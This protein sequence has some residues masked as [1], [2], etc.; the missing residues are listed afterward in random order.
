MWKSRGYGWYLRLDADGYGLY[1]VTDSACVEFERGSSAEFEG[2]FETLPSADDSQLRL[3]IRNDI[4]EYDFDRVP[5]LPPHT[6]ALDDPENHDIKDNFRFFCEAFE[7]DY[8]F[9]KLRNVDWRQACAESAKRLSR[10]TSSDE[11]FSVL[12]EL[13]LPLEDNHIV[14]TDG[15]QRVN[16]EKIADIKALIQ[17]S[18]GLRSASIGNP[19]S[20]NTLCPYLN[21]EF[22]GGQATIAGNN[23]FLWGMVE[24]GVGYLG[25]LRFF[26]LAANNVARMATD[27][28]PRRP[29]HAEFM[30]HDLEAVRQI[31]RSAMTDLSQ[32]N[33]IIVDVRLNGGGF[34]KVGMMVADHF[35]DRKRLAFSKQARVGTSLS[36]RQ[37]FHIE[38]A[39][40][41]GF[42][43]P[44]YVLTSE[45]T[46]SAGDVFALCMRALPHATL[47][48]RPSAGILSDNLTKHLPNGWQT[49]ISNEIYRAPD[50]QVFEG[51]GVPV[52]IE[53]PIF[54]K[55]DFAAGYKVAFDLARD[56]STGRK[57][58]MTAF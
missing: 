42:T 53:T 43:K 57:A 14:L 27:L 15:E 45:R 32:A 33:A 47:I 34:D 30:A 50:D 25:A 39:V 4:T 17:S 1:D 48:G 41:H 19:D 35:T 11:L 10:E 46:A 18:L 5:T 44:V 23:A 38:P 3:R 58:G 22:L 31:M 51:P 9:F 56:L 26:G 28:P 55:G 49:S 16:S 21:N 2:G 24:P 12:H 36:P 6:Q 8:A 52:D 37:E 29:E 20:I 54:V 7:Q 13:I 40:H